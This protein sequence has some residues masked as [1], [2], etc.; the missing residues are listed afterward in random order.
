M[1]QATAAIAVRNAHNDASPITHQD[2]ASTIAV[3]LNTRPARLNTIPAMAIHSI[4][5]LEGFML[6]YH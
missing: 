5:V 6:R 3:R 2:S 4:V 1:A